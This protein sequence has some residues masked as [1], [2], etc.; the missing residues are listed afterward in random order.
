MKVGDLIMCISNHSLAKTYGL[1]LG[2]EEQH[3]YK[4]SRMKG[5][6]TSEYTI[7]R[8]VKVIMG[9]GTVESWYEHLTKVVASMQS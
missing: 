9:D 8:R 2:F 6:S 3:H 1:V 5:S 4:I 7:P